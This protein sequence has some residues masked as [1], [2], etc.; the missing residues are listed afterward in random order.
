MGET[1]GARLAPG[2]EGCLWECDR[3]LLDSGMVSTAVPLKEV[4][5]EWLEHKID[6]PSGDF[7]SYLRTMSAYRRY[8]QLHPDRPDPLENVERAA[9]RHDTVPVVVPFFLITGV[10]T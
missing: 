2:E 5:R 8:L 6:W 10:R 4:R 9:R 7:L 3:R 1:L